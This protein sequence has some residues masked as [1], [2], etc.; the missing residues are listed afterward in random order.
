MVSEFEMEF[1]ISVDIPVT[2]KY[3]VNPGQ[4]LIMH[5]ADRAQEGIPAHVEDIEPVIAKDFDIDAELEKIIREDFLDDL[6]EEANQK[7][8]RKWDF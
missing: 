7:R 4:R 1:E 6:M 2:V 8:S 3:T 5:P